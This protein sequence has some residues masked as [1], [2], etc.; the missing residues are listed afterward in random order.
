MNN[1]LAIDTSG[2]AGIIAASSGEKNTTLSFGPGKPSR[3]GLAAH[4]RRVLADIGITS[5]EITYLAVGAGPGRFIRTRV[6]I[7]FING[8]AAALRLPVIRIDSLAVLACSCI[9]D[10]FEIGAIRE[11]VRGEYVFAHSLFDLSSPTFD[12]ANPWRNP[13]KIA[14]RRAMFTELSAM[15]SLWAIDGDEENEP[16]TTLIETSLPAAKV[17]GDAKAASLIQISAAGIKLNR[18]CAKAEPIYPARNIGSILR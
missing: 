6:G 15:A 14:P 9:G 1:I 11:D 13:P 17:F 18:F 4:C 16:K 3:T 5:K 8:M 10:S 12:P 2:P 7:S